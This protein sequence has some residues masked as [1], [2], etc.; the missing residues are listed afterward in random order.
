MFLFCKVPYKGLS[1]GLSKIVACV[2][3]SIYNSCGTFFN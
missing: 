1:I 2:K 3:L